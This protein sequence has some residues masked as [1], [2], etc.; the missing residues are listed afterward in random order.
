[1]ALRLA[2]RHHVVSKFYLR[3][4]ANDAEQVQTVM[5]PGTTRF[6]QS[7]GDA[8]VHTNFYTTVGHDGAATD[9]AEHAFGAIEE[10]AAEAWRLVDEGIWPLPNEERAAM[11]GWL[12]LQLLRGPANR[13]A[14]NE[15]ANFGLQLDI[16]VGGRARLREAL[17]DAGEAH[18]DETVDREWIEWFR[19][20][21]RVGIN[22]NHHVL[23]LASALPEVTEMLLGRWWLQSVFQVKALATSDHPVFVV[24]NPR[25]TEVGLGTGIANADQIAVPLTRRRS[26]VLADHRRLPGA[27]SE[28]GPDAVVPGVAKVALFANDCAVRSAR[29]FLFHHPLDDPLEPLEPLPEPRTTEV[30]VNRNVWGFLSPD[31]RKFLLDAGLVPPDEEPDPDKGSPPG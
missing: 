10:V 14:M 23:H 21:L 27:G 19:D 9:A 26:L 12:A 1:V 31:D 16:A 17:R 3:H 29:R 8:A 4:F 30:A 18:D 5:L 6:V 7:I 13:V 2:R 20:P 22:S 24:P 11:A 25:H 28:P 15:I